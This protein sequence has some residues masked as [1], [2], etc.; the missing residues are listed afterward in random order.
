MA[1][2]PPARNVA[3]MT[4][5]MPPQPFHGVI[6]GVENDLGGRLWLRDG[7][8]V[9]LHVL[10]LELDPRGDR[11]AIVAADASGRAVGRA[12]YARVYG[13]RADIA[14]DVDAR[15]WHGGLPEVLL[16]SLRDLAAARGIT[17]LLARA[18]GLDDRTRTLL[19]EQLDAREVPV[20]DDV[21]LEIATML[22]SS[23]GQGHV[24]AT[25]GAR[26]ARS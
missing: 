6:A 2:A 1:G 3:A 7:S 26:K 14:L 10:D 18:R 19:L 21:D 17:T 11:A 4:A 5:D 15:W 9:I 16:L 24:I 25:D 23:R 20:G 22:R 8:P 12:A 13:P